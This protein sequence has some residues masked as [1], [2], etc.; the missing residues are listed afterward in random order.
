[1]NQVANFAP[2]DSATN[3]I[4]SDRRPSKYWPELVADRNITGEVLEHQQFWH[5]LPDGWESMDYDEFLGKRR[6]AMAQVTQEAFR[7]LSDPHYKPMSRPAVPVAPGQDSIKTASLS[8][9]VAAGVLK[10]GDML[11]PADLERTNTIAEITDDA[12][13]ALDEHVYDS[14]RRAARADGDERSDG[15]DYWVLWDDSDPLRTLRELA[16]SL[17]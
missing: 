14:P 8:D 13:I 1:M 15:W 10:P 16:D 17:A 6:K 5:A 9:L 4:V 2:T 11:I 3:K 12:L 7:R